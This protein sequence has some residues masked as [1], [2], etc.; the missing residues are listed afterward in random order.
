MGLLKELVNEAL[1][2]H[3]AF[4]RDFHPEET[5]ASHR[6]SCS[7]PLPSCQGGGGRCGWRPG[8]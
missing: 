6:P 1:N 4:R 5:D 2:S 7:A 3:A 8:G